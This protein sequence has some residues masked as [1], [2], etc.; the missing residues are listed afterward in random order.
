[1]T[2]PEKMNAYARY[3]EAR[4]YDEG[5]F[6]SRPGD[7][8]SVIASRTGYSKVFTDNLVSQGK[9]VWR[10]GSS[11]TGSYSMHASRGNYVSLGLSYLYGP[12]IT[13]RVSNALN[14]TANWSVF[15]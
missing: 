13:P 3:Y 14:F 10:A 7:I 1:M 6:R 11:V 4:L 5:P 15:F 8:I 2:V 9:S 12:A